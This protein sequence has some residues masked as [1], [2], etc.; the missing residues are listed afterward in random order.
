[1]P[2]GSSPRSRLAWLAMYLSIMALS[3]DCAAALTHDRP[4]MRTINRNAGKV[5]IAGFL[6]Q[7]VGATRS[8]YKTGAKARF[9]PRFQVD[10]AAGP[11]F[12]SHSRKTDP[13]VGPFIYRFCNPRDKDEHQN[14]S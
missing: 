3:S 13:R 12:N 9:G 7:T 1:M 5:F 11:L 6:L 8:N 4:E 2:S 10:S 14:D